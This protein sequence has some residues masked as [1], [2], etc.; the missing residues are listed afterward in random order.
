MKARLQLLI[1]AASSVVLFAVEPTTSIWTGNGGDAKFNTLGNWK[2]I[3]G[4]PVTDAPGVSTNAIFQPP[5]PTAVDFS[6]VNAVLGL[7][8]KNTIE[9][10]YPAY[11]LKSTDATGT[12]A[13]GSGG[14]L[15]ESLPEPGV[16]ITFSPSLGLILN[17]N[18]TWDVS[19]N[20]TLLV[21]S[22][23]SGPYG[24][25]KA[26]PGVLTLSGINSYEAG[27]T[28]SGGTLVISA[29]ANLGAVPSS[30]V[31]NNLV[32]DGGGLQTTTSFDLEPNRGISI[33]TGG[34]T[35]AVNPTTTL[36]YAGRLAGSGDWSLV[37]MGT[38]K[39]SGDN[40][41]FTGR[42]VTSSGTL[43]LNSSMA[44]GDGS[45]EFNNAAVLDLNAADAIHAG[46]HEFS[47]TTQ[48][49]AGVGNA[50]SG[51]T[52]VLK[53]D[54]TLTVEVPGAL[55]SGASLVFSDF[56][57]GIGGRLMLNGNGAAVGEIHSE[58]EAI[59]SAPGTIENGGSI[60]ATLEI[61]NAQDSEFLGKIQ[62]G[63]AG[64]TL[65]VVK[66]GSGN[67]T[68][69][70]G[71][72]G[73][74]TFTGGLTV[75]Q[76]TLTLG[77]SS[78]RDNPDTI[79]IETS[80]SPVGAGILTLLGGTTLAA[81]P[82]SGGPD[83]GILLFNNL[84]LGSNESITVTIDTSQDDLTLSG[85]IGGDEGVGLLKTGDN[86][87][88][89]SGQNNSFDGGLEVAD[90]TL[91]LLPMPEMSGGLAGSGTLTLR[92]GTT[93][94]LPI[95]MS[96]SLSNDILLDDP[97]SGTAGASIH[98]QQ[99][100]EGMAALELSGMIADGWRN[101]GT[102]L[103]LIKTG[104][105]MLKLD[106]ANTF[107][108]GL[109]VE[110][111]A[112]VITRSSQTEGVVI[113]GPVGVGLLKMGDG[114]KLGAA[115]SGSLTL[116]NDIELG[117]EGGFG[118]QSD[119]LILAGN[120]GQ[121]EGTGSL[122]IGGNVVLEGTANTFTGP[123]SI[124]CGTLRIFGDG[125]LGT[126]PVDATAG[127][128]HLTFVDGGLIANGTMTLAPTRGIV[129]GGYGGT[130]TAPANTTFTVGGTISGSSSEAALTKAGAGTLV[131][132]GTNTYAG[133]TKIEA[134]N[135]RTT[136]TGTLPATTALGM[137]IGT[138][139]YIDE[140]QRIARF[141]GDIAAEV[142]I[143]IGSG[144]TFTVAPTAEALLQGNAGEFS[145]W[146]SGS[147]AFELAGVPDSLL[148]LRGDLTY[149][150]GTSIATGNTLKISGA[151]LNADMSAL[152]HPITA[153]GTLAFYRDEEADD[154]TVSGSITGSGRVVSYSGFTVLTGTGNN[155]SGG[156][157]IKSGSVLVGAADGA[158]GASSGGI[159]VRDA[160][161]VALMNGAHVSN[162][163]TLESGSTIAGNGTFASN[164][165]VGAGV[166][167]KPELNNE[168]TIGTLTFNELTLNGGGTY[169]W[170]MLNA[171]VYDRVSVVNPTTLH[172][173]QNAADA[174]TFKLTP[175]SAAGVIGPASGFI[176]G[177]TVTFELFQAATMDG[178]ANFNYTIDHSL[179]DE[180]MGEA[181]FSLSLSGSSIL[182]NFTPVPEPSTW[183]L[184]I[185]GLAIVGVGALRRR[186]RH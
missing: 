51:G 73:T 84:H 133:W 59:S 14:I 31:A 41:A 50:I 163:V 1:F 30:P 111:G 138:K 156:T 126:A 64:G 46:Y 28:L 136:G 160:G 67:L 140:S 128:N 152:S 21:G 74:S 12:L 134:G 182:L 66:T 57:E 120:I 17:A 54:S 35:L 27:T 15:V 62:D 45:L 112:V 109:V 42:I 61:G 65:S 53:G 11:E 177:Q 8:F 52:L 150:G 129:L 181:T 123:T 4:N 37:G 170:N 165:I 90:G 38:L 13:L 48:I 121:G 22:T 79:Q 86:T 124:E 10:N 157:E 107:S 122:R 110:E 180:Y 168:N 174:F 77:R 162:A 33:A 149:S 89:L 88:T 49:N 131:L 142:E 26:G 72:G 145:G 63:A 139:L 83:D 176:P 5:T 161:V 80:S 132:S 125:S 34:G 184:L 94:T 105:G 119:P 178:F 186:Q 153:D 95:D 82:E 155:Y 171:S 167:L 104:S 116:D 58:T 179:F 159:L 24:L 103:S 68:L 60:N 106:G 158:F 40:T 154:L 113:A 39:L 71:V 175:L 115:G 85:D 135:L 97:N 78:Y 44:L 108:G 9:Y 81:T 151:A 36:G 144:N 32:F 185:T 2:D 101:E 96:L 169:E 148:W 75:E 143:A 137:E 23:V 183:A 69:G 25:I 87:L 146:L 173:E 70:G 100:S 141:L 118:A 117:G 19:A 76:G 93:L 6:S 43:E 18:Q 47:G 164:V 56:A 7:S 98:V 29:D 92:R 3:D 147:G 91:K 127:A 55:A 99:E 16:S 166:T 130:L 102:A 172:F 20:A 114:T